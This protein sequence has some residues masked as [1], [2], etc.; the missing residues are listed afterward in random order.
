LKNKPALS[1][2]RQTSSLRKTLKTVIDGIKCATSDLFK[3]LKII[4]IWDFNENCNKFKCPKKW[5]KISC[6]RYATRYFN[7][8]TPT[9]TE[10]SMRMNCV[11]FLEIQFRNTSQVALFQSR[12]SEL[13]GTK[14]TKTPTIRSTSMNFGG[15]CTLKQS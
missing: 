9:E 7:W 11:P 15:F 12:N 2:L 3:Q 5:Q 4:I 10:H 1:G 6:V 8:S 14:W 13:T